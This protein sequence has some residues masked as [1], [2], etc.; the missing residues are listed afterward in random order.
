MEIQRTY[1]E[2][3][4]FNTFYKLDVIEYPPTADG[5]LAADR[6]LCSQLLS[7]RTASFLTGEVTVFTSPRFISCLDSASQRGEPVIKLLFHCKCLIEED[8]PGSAKLV[9]DAIT[10]LLNELERRWKKQTAGQI[11]DPARARQI[12]Q[13]A[14]EQGVLQLFVLKHR[15]TEAPHSAILDDRSLLIQQVH[16]PGQHAPQWFIGNPNGLLPE[17]RTEHEVYERGALRLK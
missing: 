11:E 16:V 15:V 13:Q 8:P 2:R 6:R 14:V 7:S 17:Y 12:I 1:L 10:E 5:K 3:A 9:D 4:L